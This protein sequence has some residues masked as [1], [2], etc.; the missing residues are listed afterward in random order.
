MFALRCQ[1]AVA[2]GFT[3]I[4]LLVVVAI[5]TLLISILLPSLGQAREQAKRTKCGSNLKSIGTAVATC[6]AE[7]NEYGPSW[8]DGEP[9]PPVNHQTF[10]LTWT[11]VLFDL[12]YLG[13][14]GAA[15]CPSDERPDEV[16]ALRGASNWNFRWVRQ[17]GVNE[18]QEPGVRN[19]YALN[20]I[21]H[22]NFKEDRYPGGEARQ[23]YA[24]DGW[25]CWT[26]NINAAWLF[27]AGIWPGAPQNPMTF[28]HEFSTMAGWRHGKEFRS[29]ILYRDGHVAVLTPRRPSSL[30]ELV[31]KTVD[32]VN[33]YTWLPGE[34]PTRRYMDKYDAQVPEWKERI[35][36]AIQVKNE[37]RGGKIGFGDNIHPYNYPDQ[38]SAA[39]RTLNNAWIKLPN[40][41]D[42]RK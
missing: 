37:Q 32:T 22:F 26:S 27:H 1:R 35:P 33:T 30:D 21:M 23:F 17:I 40:R 29:N 41:S 14:V 18:K 7:N 12:D 38:L 4:E 36:K 6:Y 3:L 5:I 25:W 13:D 16:A 8:D 34:K 15:L 42:Q 28:I 9:G 10:M 19:S 31:N 2:R 39:W 11:D 20:V 24:M